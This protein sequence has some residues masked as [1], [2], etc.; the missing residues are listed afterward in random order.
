MTGTVVRKIAETMSIGMNICVVGPKKLT[1]FTTALA[2]WTL[3]TGASM[4]LI[5]P[6]FRANAVRRYEVHVVVFFSFL[7]S[8]TSTGR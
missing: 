1:P 7:V 5:R 3:T 2:G 6:V 4:L 8:N